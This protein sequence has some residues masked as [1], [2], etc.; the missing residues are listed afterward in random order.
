MLA[1]ANDFNLETAV[2]KIRSGPDWVF[3][4]DASLP[5]V[6]SKITQTFKP[7]L[8]I[9]SKDARRIVVELMKGGE[10]YDIKIYGK[11]HIFN[12]MFCAVP[13]I[14]NREDWQFFGGWLGYPVA[15]KSVGALYPLSLDE[16]GKL[17]LTGV[18]RGIMGPAYRGVEEFD[19]L[20][21]R[22]GRRYEEDK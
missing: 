19:Y 16:T 8:G 14:A 21:K 20:L 1:A 4:T 3:E 10:E 6:E 22:F 9:D 15:D 13:E 12:K 2:E 17:R 5:K 18:C 11:V 7:Y